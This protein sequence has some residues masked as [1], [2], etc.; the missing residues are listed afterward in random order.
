MKAV[1][2]KS[3]NYE[4]KVAKTKIMPILGKDKEYR[5]RIDILVK[6]NKLLKL[7]TEWANKRIPD[8]ESE[9][10]ALKTT[11]NAIRKQRIEK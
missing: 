7:R 9:L 2:P 10:E 1:T 8:L 3:G 4:T 6:E 11:I 5:L